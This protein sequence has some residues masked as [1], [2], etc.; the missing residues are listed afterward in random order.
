MIQKYF[1]FGVILIGGFRLVWDS[2]AI[3]RA[4]KNPVY[5]SDFLRFIFLFLTGCMI[6]CTAIS[7]APFEIL[8]R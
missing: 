2:T 4:S 1:I 8:V 6:L 7:M 5:G 3:F